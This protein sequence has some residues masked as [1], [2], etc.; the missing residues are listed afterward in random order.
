[1]T[2]EEVLQN[3]TK[4]TTKSEHLVKTVEILGCQHFLAFMSSLVYVLTS[5]RVTMRRIKALSSVPAP[6]ILLYRRS[7][8]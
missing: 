3:F 7:A 6:F 8:K 1:M 4:N 2:D 5:Q